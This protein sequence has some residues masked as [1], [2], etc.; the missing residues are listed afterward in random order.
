[1][2]E[3]VDKLKERL[4][5]IQTLPRKAK[6]PNLRPLLPL[7]TYH[8]LKENGLNH[9]FIHSSDL[10]RF[11]GLDPFKMGKVITKEL[12]RIRNEGNNPYGPIHI[13][14]AVPIHNPQQHREKLMFKVR[15]T[16]L[17]NNPLEA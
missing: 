14:G 5:Y 3:E 13:T 8:Y 15:T 11:Y 9:S 4:S 12:Q 1:M 17:V 10:V 7:M 2:S 6:A 16:G